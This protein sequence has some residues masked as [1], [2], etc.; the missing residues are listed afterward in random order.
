[1]KSI[2]QALVVATVIQIISM[3]GMSVYMFSLA[4]EQAMSYATVAES[5]A[6]VTAAEMVL[7]HRNDVQRQFEYERIEM[8]SYVDNAVQREVIQ[9]IKR[10]QQ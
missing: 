3:F 1:M 8:K 6:R 7:Q 4:A 5:N 2:V 9:I 10:N